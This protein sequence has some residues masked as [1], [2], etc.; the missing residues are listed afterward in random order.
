MLIELLDGENEILVT[1]LDEVTAAATDGIYIP[2]AMY[3]EENDIAVSSLRVWKKRFH[4]EAV[5]IF[6]RLYVKKGAEI[7]TRHYKKHQKRGLN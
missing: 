3:A 6:G 2:A 1:G 5:T 7:E 4:V